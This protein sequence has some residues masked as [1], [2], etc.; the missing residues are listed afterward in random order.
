MNE[1]TVTLTS[2]LGNRL[3]QTRLNVDLTQQQVADIIGKS[4]TAIERAEKGKCTL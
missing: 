2:V 4:R 3:K 1:K